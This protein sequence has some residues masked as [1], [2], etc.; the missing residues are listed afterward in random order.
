MAADA[1]TNRIRFL[2]WRQRRAAIVAVLVAAAIV[3]VAFV[4]L[5]P[6]AP[7]PIRVGSL[8]PDFSFTLLNNS[9]S[10]LASY[11]G[12]SLLLWWIATWCPSC[13]AGTQLFEQSYLSQF[14]SAGVAVLEIELYNNL[15][16]PGPSLA[17]FASEHGYVGQADWV[18]GTSSASSTNLY[19]PHA[20]TDLYYVIGPTGL[21]LSSGTTTGPALP[22]ILSEASA[23]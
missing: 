21:L 13:S 5:R 12:H 22:S 18:F 10:S 3:V 14:E 4:A 20:E 7:S 11:R 23:G 16:Q 2:R 19:D 6:A 8:A 9:S 17:E 1:P 15:G